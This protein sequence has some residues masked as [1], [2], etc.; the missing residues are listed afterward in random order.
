MSK[1]KEDIQE[2]INKHQPDIERLKKMLLNIHSVACI[3]FWYWRLGNFKKT[4]NMHEDLMA[5]DALATSVVISYGRL[6]SSGNGS[7]K[8]SSKI[9][10]PSFKHVHQE[11]LNLRN[12]KYAHHGGHESIESTLEIHI[13]DECIDIIP[14]LEFIVCFGA[15]KEWAPLLEWLDTYMYK[16]IEE[17]LLLLK[18]KTGIEW[19][20]LHGDPPRW[21]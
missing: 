8:L 16:T 12:T 4:L 14:N 20:M 6:F 7:T 11:I 2:L 21:V 9:I 19:N 1:T 3:R 13:K 18:K 17:Q 5:M 10:P 15:P